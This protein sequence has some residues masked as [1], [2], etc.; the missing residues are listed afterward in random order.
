M[1]EIK[2]DESFYAEEGIGKIFK[3]KGNMYKIDSV[4]GMGVHKIVYKLIDLKSNIPT[5]VLKIY[6][7]NNSEFFENSKRVYNKFAADPGLSKFIIKGSEY[8]IKDGWGMIF[9]PYLDGIIYTSNTRLPPK[10]PEKYHELVEMFNDM[11]RHFEAYEIC[12]ELIKK[13]PLQPFY[14]YFMYRFHLLWSLDDLSKAFNSI[15]MCYEI[16]PDN[17]EYKK[18]YFAIKGVI[19]S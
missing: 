12:K 7:K 2:I 19:E 5:H 1:E 9:E 13:H 8:I 4:L 10:Y 18:Q 14:H 11:K 17:K 3:H 15:S 16:E 6:R